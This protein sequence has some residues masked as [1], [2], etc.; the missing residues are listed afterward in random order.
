PAAHGSLR[1]HRRPHRIPP[2]TS[3]GPDLRVGV[4]TFSSPGFAWPP[5]PGNCLSD[6]AERRVPLAA[7]ISAEGGDRGIP[8]RD[9]SLTP[10]VLGVLRTPA[11]R[12]HVLAG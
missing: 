1:H 5:S 2:R 9:R 8:P 7:E 3:R 4:L 12:R 11:L 6:I 10:A